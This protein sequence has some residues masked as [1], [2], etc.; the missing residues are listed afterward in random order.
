MKCV[1]CGNW[2]GSEGRAL[3]CLVTALLDARKRASAAEG[4]LEA[5]RSIG[6]GYKRVTSPEAA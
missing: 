6:R 1:A 4:A 2:H 5:I 3:H